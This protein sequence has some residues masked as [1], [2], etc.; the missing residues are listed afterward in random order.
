M[1][2]QLIIA[3]VL[4]GPGLVLAIAFRAVLLADDA[5]P[6]T[7]ALQSSSPSGGEPESAVLAVSPTPAV[8]DPYFPLL[9]AVALNASELPGYS[10]DRA[11]PGVIHLAP[12]PYADVF[13]RRFFGI[14]QTGPAPN[15]WI[16]MYM[17]TASASHEDLVRALQNGTVLKDATAEAPS[18]FRLLGPASAS[19]IDEAALSN[20]LYDASVNYAPG[21]DYE[22]ATLIGSLTVVLRYDRATSDTTDAQLRD[23]TVAKSAQ[24]QRKVLSSAIL[25]AALTTPPIPNAPN[26]LVATTIDGEDLRL[27]WSSTSD[28]EDGFAIYDAAAQLPVATVPAQTSSYTLVGLQPASTYCAYVYAFNRAGSS[29]LSDQACAQ[30]SP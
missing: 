1:R 10:L 26:S 23:E 20:S 15:L 28:D 18:N 17:P 14:S 6:S 12:L 24:Q 3:L 7:L 13:V 11:T 21:T 9:S 29:N 2:K 4:V 8:Q 16:F 5:P 30:T 25:P 27:D 19:R 22:V